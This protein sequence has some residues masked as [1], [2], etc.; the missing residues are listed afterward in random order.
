MIENFIDNYKKKDKTLEILKKIKRL[1]N[2]TFLE[3]IILFV[4]SKDFEKFKKEK[5]VIIYR[6][7]IIKEK[8]KIDIFTKEGVIYLFRP[9]KFKELCF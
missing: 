9:L 6:N 2:K 3:L 8:Q 5:R 4:N 7:G 1:F